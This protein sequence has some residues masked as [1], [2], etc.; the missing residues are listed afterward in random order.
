MAV[1]PRI[2]RT[3]KMIAHS[4]TANAADVNLVKACPIISKDRGRHFSVTK[5]C[6][7]WR[8]GNSTVD[9]VRQQ[10]HDW[11]RVWY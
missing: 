6:P 2:T 10:Y 5:S 4:T 11:T 8:E 1:A 7:D 9:I 3:A